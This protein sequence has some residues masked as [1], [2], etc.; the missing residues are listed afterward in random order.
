M[1]VS[2]STY[3]SKQTAQLILEGPVCEASN[4][5]EERFVAVSLFRI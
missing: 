5:I 2:L 3:S 1:T 4:N